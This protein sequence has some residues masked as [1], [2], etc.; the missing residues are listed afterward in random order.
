MF[1]WRVGGKTAKEDKKTERE[2][3]LRVIYRRRRPQRL[4]RK[5]EPATAEAKWMGW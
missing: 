4:Q 2:S 3:E 5:G 1:V